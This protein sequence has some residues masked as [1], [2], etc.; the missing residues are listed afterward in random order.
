MQPIIELK[1]ITKTFSSANG[2]FTALDGVSLTVEEGDVYG[3]IGASGA[4]KSTLVRCIN[5]L[6]RP[7]SG[8]VLIEGRDL[9]SCNKSELLKT[10]Q[11]IGMIFQNFCLLEQ[12]NC[13]DNVRF[14]LS[15]AGVPKQKA[16]ARAEELLALVG[17]SDKARSYPSQLSGGQ[18]QR[19]AIARALA[20][21]PKV[22]LLDEA[23]SALD[24]KTTDSILELLL[25]IHQKTGITMVFITHEMRVVE[26]V[27]NKV[28][29]IDGGKIVETG[30]VKQ[31]FSAP[32]SDK[33]KE[34]VLPRA[35]I[36]NQPAETLAD[37]PQKRK[38]LRLIFDGAKSDAPVLSELV[39]NLG[40]DFNILFAETKTV[41]GTTV[42]QMLIELPQNPADCK[43][44][45][46]FLQSRGVT[47]REETAFV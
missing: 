40:V 2:E 45:A 42:G 20:A 22:L 46:E 47:V 34:L 4:G 21:D 5:L 19:V 9:I 16:K 26:S 12:K 18:K 11:K 3:I 33:A 14:P 10:R 43:A 13:L 6:E 25:S 28:A 36:L 39:K 44:A 32:V 7:T 41:A 1:N 30:S 37:P 35:R 31:V 17:L 29:V 27:C 24:P 38:C 23:T 15:V 8:T